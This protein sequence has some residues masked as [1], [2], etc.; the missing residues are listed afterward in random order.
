MY[1][2]ADDFGIHT[3]GVYEEDGKW[4][5]VFRGYIG[6]PF[7]T[8]E[9]AN[10]DL[11]N[12]DPSDIVGTKEDPAFE[13]NLQKGINIETEHKGMLTRLKEYFNQNK[14]LPSDSM[15]YQWI[16]LDH[17]A[18]SPFYYGPEFDKFEEQLKMQQQMMTTPAENN[19]VLSLFLRCN[20]IKV[21]LQNID[22]KKVKAIAS[23]IKSAHIYKDGQVLRDSNGQKLTWT[24]ELSQIEQDTGTE[25]YYLDDENGNVVERS[26]DDLMTEEE[27]GMT[28]KKKIKGWSPVDRYKLH[29]EDLV[30]GKVYDL[31][32]LETLGYQIG[33]ETAKNAIIWEIDGDGWW[34]EKVGKDEFKIIRQYYESTPQKEDRILNMLRADV[35]NRY[36]ANAIKDYLE[37]HG[38]PAG[39]VE[40]PSYDENQIEAVVD[41]NV[42]YFT[43]DEIGITN[44]EMGSLIVEPALAKIKAF[45]TF[46]DAVIEDMIERKAIRLGYK[47]KAELKELMRRN[48]NSRNGYDNAVQIITQILKER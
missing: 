23:R 8:E 43:Y 21:L 1:I 26:L 41:G 5:W 32:M 20:E 25:I 2:K 31:K 48:K 10:E 9:D 33:S 35:V 34:A 18:E 44:E 47:T 42:E 11:R 37:K 27:Y 29:S 16:A 15:I 4:Y 39:V 46:D 28:A 17:L 6:G 36:L 12:F 30:P 40:V 19:Y 24:G 3:E 45:G 14:A 22:M 7:D 38:R 13:E